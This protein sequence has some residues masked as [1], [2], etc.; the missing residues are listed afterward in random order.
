M[1]KIGTLKKLN[2]IP[3]YFVFRIAS[4]GQDGVGISLSNQTSKLTKFLLKE[5]LPGFCIFL[6]K[7]NKVQTKK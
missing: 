6:L 5:Y 3:K 2:L 4:K 7:R 1:V